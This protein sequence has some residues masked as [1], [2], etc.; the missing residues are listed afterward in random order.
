MEQAATHKS[1]NTPLI[2]GAVALGG[3]LLYKKIIFP[4][5]VVPKRTVKYV[6]YNKEEV[7]VGNVHNYPR[8]VLKPLGE[9]NLWL[10]VETRML[11]MVKYFSDIFA[12]KVS[13]QSVTFRG[14]VT[15]DGTPWPVTETKKIS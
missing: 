5:V 4:G 1:S 2:L 6:T 13:H 9:T 3:Y 7:N 10:T 15:I 11:P 12:G 8:K 14:T